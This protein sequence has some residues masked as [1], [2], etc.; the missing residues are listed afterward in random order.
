MINRKLVEVSIVDM[1]II[2]KQAINELAFISEHAKKMENVLSK[3]SSNAYPK[4]L[5]LEITNIGEIQN[6]IDVELWDQLFNKTW[7]YAALKEEER[8]TLNQWL[9]SDSVAKFNKEN[10]SSILNYFNVYDNLYMQAL[11]NVLNQKIY[12]NNSL[13][14]MMSNTSDSFKI[15]VYG[16]N[17]WIISNEKLASIDNISHLLL[18]GDDSLLPSI[19]GVLEKKEGHNLREIKIS[20]INLKTVEVKILSNELLLKI[21]KCMEECN[22]NNDKTE[23]MKDAGSFEG[24]FTVS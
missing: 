18:N 13:F 12:K 14:N 7:I 15:E 19:K 9:Y 10:I 21:V 20:Y 5:M 4:Q 2:R 22:Y 8:K 3:L 23:Y 16:K 6:T 17:E 24:I 11:N 1:L